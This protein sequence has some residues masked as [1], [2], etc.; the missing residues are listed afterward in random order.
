MDELITPYEPV[1]VKT[2]HC[3]IDEGLMSLNNMNL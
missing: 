3:Y 1:F 2:M